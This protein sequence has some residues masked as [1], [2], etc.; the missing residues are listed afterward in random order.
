M[1]LVGM[2][3][4]VVRK[5]FGKLV[6]Y[7]KLTLCLF[8]GSMGD[9]HFQGCLP[10]TFPKNQIQIEAWSLVIPFFALFEVIHTRVK[11]AKPTH[12]KLVSLNR[13]QKRKNSPLVI[14]MC[15]VK[16]IAETRLHAQSGRCHTCLK[17]GTGKDFDICEQ[18]K[19]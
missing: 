9:I 11:S 4:T 10:V 12:S 18:R 19:K 7:G 16:F 6:P 17:F 13:L 15:A 3:S 8:C 1:F 2:E 14:Q 5:Q